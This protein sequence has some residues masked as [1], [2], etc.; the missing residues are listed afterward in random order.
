M[1]FSGTFST[2]LGGVNVVVG[3]KIYQDNA[4]DWVLT[5]TF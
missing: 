4:A 2:K 1:A 3:F 5:T